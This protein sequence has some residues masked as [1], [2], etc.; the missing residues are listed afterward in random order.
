MQSSK[1]PKINFPSPAHLYARLHTWFLVRP[2]ISKHAMHVSLLAMFGFTLLNAGVFTFNNGRTSA[3]TTINGQA[4]GLMSI[5]SAK[6]LLKTAEASKQLT[7][8][9]NGKT[10][11]LNSQEIGVTVNADKTFSALESTKGW[12]HLPV[13]SA[14]GNLFTDTK[15]VYDIN[16]ATLVGSL[17]PLVKEDITPAKNASVTVPADPKAPV[18][19]TPEATGHE[20]TAVI[21]ASKL[22]EAINNGDFTAK[23]NPEVL[24]PKWTELDIRAFLPSVE[25]AR[26]TSLTFQAEDK[27]LV[28]TSEILA[29]MLV[30][31]T[32]GTKLKMSLDENLLKAYLEKQAVLFYVAPIA[33][34][35]VQKD[36]TEISRIEGANGKQLDSQATAKLAVTAF[37]NGLTSVQASLATVSPQVLVTKTY[38]NTS[39][40]LYKTIEDFANSHSGT[41]RVAAVE[42]NGPSNRS[43]FYNS[44][45]SVI[46]ASTFK[47]FLSYGILQQVEAGQITMGSSTSQGTVSECMY[48]M[49]HISDNT[50]ASA[51]QSVLGWVA[52][53]KKLIADGFTST[54]L[55][56]SSG[57]DKHST[58]RDEM[59]LVT[60]LYNHELLTAESTDY[61][62]NLMENQIY[63]SGIPAG[64]NGSVVAD[65]VG[66]LY[67]L[68]HDIGVVYSPKATYAL[69]ILTD[70]AGGWT[71]VRLL[72]R[73]VYDFYNQ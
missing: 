17:L 8:S 15:P 36:G 48:K 58:A 50:C 11:V 44:D 38:S 59:N 23:L 21:A 41:Y 43:A 60:K 1:F 30:I 14:V 61:L 33:V 55:N 3:F 31:D 6:Q 20:M 51:L 72:A 52:F 32:S 68:N 22:I 63:R 29:P 9:I 10:Y 12:R 40:G 35:T 70:G 34:K 64:S 19:I 49:I 73:Q 28:L 65:K 42:L 66:F 47:L 7:A 4:Y 71:N 39:T 26:K 2:K 18:T 62:F 67:A 45:S 25:S 54:Q 27:K 13:I 24:Q 56:N 46:T 69:V 53:D 37:E 16:E 5:D 57:G